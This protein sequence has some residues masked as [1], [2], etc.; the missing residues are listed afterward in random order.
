MSGSIF[1]SLITAITSLLLANIARFGESLKNHSCPSEDQF[2]QYQRKL[3]LVQLDSHDLGNAQINDR[4][5]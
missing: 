2:C 4:G 3:Y 5:K 1:G